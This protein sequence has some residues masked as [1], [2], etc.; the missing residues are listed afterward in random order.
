MRK[1]IFV[2]T[3]ALLLAILSCQFTPQT[4]E[5][6]PAQP[7]NTPAIQPSETPAEPGMEMIEPTVTFTITQVI[8]DT[9]AITPRPHSSEC[10]NLES[11]LYDLTVAQDPENL[12]QTK[13]LFYENGATRVV[14]QLATP[15]ADTSFLAEYGVQ[16]ET[17]TGSL[18]QALVPPERLC[19]LSNDPR[20]K[21]VREPQAPALPQ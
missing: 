9:V 8:T 17:Q 13:G 20:V 5:T 1:T 12:A 21:F 6:Q 3:L 15:E 4:L 16:I 11:R 14:I 10:P 2:P 18:V 7:S 19:D